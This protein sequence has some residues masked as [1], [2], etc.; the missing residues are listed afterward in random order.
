V[1]TVV[2]PFR[3]ASAKSR[4]GRPDLARAMLEDV[5]EALRVELV[6]HIDEV[7]K[8]ALVPPAGPAPQEAT[9]PPETSLGQMPDGMT[10]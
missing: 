2:V 9:E 6:G 5:L 3:G 7:L 1:V 4:L 10:H 8:I